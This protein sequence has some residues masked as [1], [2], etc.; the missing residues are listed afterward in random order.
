MALLDN[1]VNFIVTYHQKSG[2]SNSSNSVGVIPDVI[3]AGAK[4]INPRS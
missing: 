2:Q 1:L 3:L 4:V